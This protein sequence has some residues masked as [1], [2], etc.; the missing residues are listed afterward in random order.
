MPKLYSFDEIELVLK[1]LGFISVTQK[2]S[3]AKFKHQDG[4]IVIL[5]MNK[6]KFP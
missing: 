1:K 2:G 5:P 3:H 6:K 4:R